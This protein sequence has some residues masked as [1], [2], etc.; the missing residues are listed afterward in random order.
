[1]S[2]VALL[3]S[4]PAAA[5]LLGWLSLGLSVWSAALGAGLGLLALGSLARTVGASAATRLLGAGAAL[6]LAPWLLRSF[7][8]KGGERVRLSVLPDDGGPRLLSKLYP[9]RDGTLLAAKL[10][11]MLRPLHDVESGQFPEIL[12]QA[13]ERTDPPASEVPTP[14]IATYLG[15]Q[16]PSQF[17]TLVISPPPG[18]A[19]ADAALVFLHGYA[20]NFYIYCWELA[21]AAAAANLVT[22]CP[23]MD[24]S[25]AWWT[26]EGEQILRATFEHAHRAGMNRIYLAGLS[27][28]A[29]GASVLALSH[30]NEISGLVLISGTRTAQPPALPTL[31]VQGQS[32]QMMPAASARAY[33]ARSPLAQYREL[34][35]GHLI[36]LS[37]YQQVRPLIAGFLL[38]L[39]Q[40]APGSPAFVGKSKR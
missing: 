1:M 24:A 10:L 33:A 39:E 20:G 6:V 13:F 14:A 22:F 27:N 26:P 36:L 25:G 18:R 7:T 5:L 23:S 3:L 2:W 35:G 31:V 4:A 9:E 40:R 28:G 17:D 34:A 38:G 12:Q 16:S 11:S 19:A 30:Q 21:Q 32:D 37:R 15:M 8:V 29:A